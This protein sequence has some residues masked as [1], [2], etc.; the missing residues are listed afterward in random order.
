MYHARISDLFIFDIKLDENLKSAKVAVIAEVE[1]ST[2]DV[3]FRIYD[4]PTNV[5]MDKTVKIANENAYVDFTIKDPEL[6]Y[7]AGYG[8]Q[9]LY[10]VVATLTDRNNVKLDSKEKDFGIRRAEL[11]QRPLKDQPGT[12]FFFRINNI[13]IF[14]GGS[15]WIPADNF[16]PRIPP[17]KYRDWVKLVADGNQRMIRVWGGGVYED[18]TFYDACDQYGILVW[19]DFLFGCGNYPAHPSFLESVKREA[20]ANVKRLRHH[21]SIVIWAGNNED[22]QYQESEGL[23]Y[24]PENKDAESWLKTNFPARYIYEKLLPE[25]CKELVPDTYYHPGSPFGGTD[26]RDPTVGD[27]HQWNVWHGTQEKYQNW[28]QL[29]GRFVSEFGME[30]FPDVRTVDGYLPK[31]KDDED[32]YSQSEIVDWHNKADGHERRLALYLVENIRYSPEPLEYFIYCT[33]LMQAECLSSAYRLWRRQWK[34][35]GREYC[36]G[37]LVWQIDDCWPVTSWSIVDYLLRPKLAYWAIKREMGEL[38]VGM[39]RVEKVVPRDRFTRV[40]VERTYHVEIW[41]SNL[42]LRDRRVDVVVMAWNVEAGERTY[43]A[44]IK[45]RVLLLQNHSTELADMEVPVKVSDV[46]EEGRTVVAAYLVEDGVQVARY[47]NWPEPLKYVHLQ[48]PKHLKV[49]V[50]QDGK[51]VDV[52]A[53]VAVKGVALDCED[54]DVKFE[55]NCVDLVPGEIVS[56]AMKGG[57]KETKIGAKYLGMV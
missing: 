24:D 21:P 41:G 17:Y 45:E 43:C 33:Q 27:I 57:D 18:D 32:R 8:N 34:G 42:G 13:P 35:P 39:K 49:E 38:A 3:R 55:D 30:A 40:Y 48:R 16:L 15:N 9:P 37:A 28:D 2:R 44:T 1:G 5:I 53:E 51:R 12:S 36:G 54:E 47:I 31:G 23:T 22:Y 50:S 52:S 26:T 29:A 6:W 7:P 20:T 11:I 4:S 25:V 46:G 14:C 10:S 56:I 19:Q